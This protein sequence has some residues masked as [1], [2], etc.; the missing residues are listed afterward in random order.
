MSGK[1]PIS[2]CTLLDF[3]LIF[4]MLLLAAAIFIFSISG[5]NDDASVCIVSGNDT[6]Y[7]SLSDERTVEL[8]TPVGKTVVK[9]E[10]GQAYIE[11][12]ECENQICVRS[13]RVKKTGDTVICAPAGVAVMIVKS[14][15]GVYENAD[16]AAG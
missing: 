11:S 6:M 7:Y 5:S 8:Q 13:G 1:M 2:K 15:G 12:S 3:L 4:V 9:I 10:G 14:G 16:A